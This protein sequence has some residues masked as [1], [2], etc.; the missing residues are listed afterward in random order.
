MTLEVVKQE[1]EEEN[2]A[3]EKNRARS[4]SFLGLVLL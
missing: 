2:K 3:V 1:E 4:F